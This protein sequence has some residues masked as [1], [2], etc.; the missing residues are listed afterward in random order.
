MGYPR[1]KS[2]RGKWL[3]ISV[4][5]FLLLLTAVAILFF[6]HVTAVLPTERAAERWAR[7]D[8][9][10]GQVSAYFPQHHGLTQGS[11]QGITNWIRGSLVD[12]GFSLGPDGQGGDFSYAYSAQGVLQIRSPY[13]GEI[14]AY[15]SFVGGDFFLFQS[16]P[17]LSGSYLPLDSI[18]RD[19]VLLD[20][21]LSWWLFG[22]TDVAGMPV[23]IEGDRH[24]V[25]GVYRP[26]GDFFS[27]AAYGE[28]PQ[29]I[30]YYD[31]V[32]D[33]I[34]PP[35]TALQ[36]VLPN[37]IT[38]FAASILSEALENGGIEE[39]QFFLVNN[40][41]RY[42]ISALIQVIRDYGSR[43]MYRAGLSLPFWENAGRM[44]EDYAALALV[45]VFLLLL[46]P[47]L[48]FA[49][50]LV[51]RWRRRKFRLFRWLFR[52]WE[53]RSEAKKRKRRDTSPG[54]TIGPETRR[55]NEQAFDIEEIIRSVRESEERDG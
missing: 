29:L 26:F 4:C 22:A 17:L 21:T 15:A 23:Y 40:T 13:Q 6:R 48:R 53:D 41:D 28:E 32:A 7:G 14:S 8:T 19:M 45:L 1:R 18:N 11:V 27:R 2:R 52:S 12:Q 39:D 50:Y 43:S 33:S 54:K 51:L 47:V 20:E 9:H 44:T 24:I 30:L 36:V 10:F 42:R 5:L 37:P 3:T 25:A 31:A 46:F 35:I 49:V 38:G 55:E 16:L 34:M